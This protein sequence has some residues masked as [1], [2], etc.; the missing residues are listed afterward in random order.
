MILQVIEWEARNLST[1]ILND[2]LQQAFDTK[3]PMYQVQINAML[4]PSNTSINDVAGKIKLSID[5]TT[6]SSGE[7]IT[8]TWGST[9]DGIVTDTDRIAIF[10]PQELDFFR[11]YMSTKLT[12]KT[13]K[14]LLGTVTLYCPRARTF[15]STESETNI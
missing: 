4:E 2:I 10:K 6:Y 8:I 11:A 13:E 7:P 12:R 3:D 5:K 9:E 1:I 14:D 15:F